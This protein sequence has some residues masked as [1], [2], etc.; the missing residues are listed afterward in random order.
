MFSPYPSN[1]RN[2]LMSSDPQGQAG[3]LKRIIQKNLQVIDVLL[4]GKDDEDRALRE[5]LESR[6][7]NRQ[8]LIQNVE[9][10]NSNI[11][12]YTIP[13]NLEIAKQKRL[14]KPLYKGDGSELLNCFSDHQE[15]AKF[16]FAYEIYLEMF[17]LFYGL[18][19]IIGFQAFVGETA[20]YF[21]CKDTGINF[22]LSHC[23]NCV[24]G[25]SGQ[26]YV[27]LV[28]L[29]MQIFGIII[30]KILFNKWKRYLLNK[31]KPELKYYTYS[32]S[33]FCL[34]VRDLPKETSLQSIKEFFEKTLALE[35]PIKIR[36]AIL[37]REG[38]KIN[39]NIKRR[40]EYQRRKIQ[41]ISQQEGLALCSEKIMEEFSEELSSKKKRRSTT[42]F[43]VEIQNNLK[44]PDHEEHLPDFIGCAIVCFET[45][46]M[47]NKVKEFYKS[48]QRRYFCLPRKKSFPHFNKANIK[49]HNLPDPAD[50]IWVNINASKTVQ[51]IKKAI[52]F[53]I[54][55]VMLIIFSALSISLV[56]WIIL[57]SGNF[58]L[59]ATLFS[60]QFL[61]GAIVRIIGK[62]ASQFIAYKSQNELEKF[63]FGYLLACDIFVFN[64]STWGYAF[65]YEESKTKYYQVPL[66][67]FATMIL[68]NGLFY[69]QAYLKDFI[70]KHSKRKQI[71]ADGTNYLTQREAEEYY[72]RMKLNFLRRTIS[73]FL[74]LTVAMTLYMVYP[75]A[76][77]VCFLVQIVFILID[78]QLIARYYTLSFESDA[79]LALECYRIFNH[80]T[81]LQ[82]SAHTIFETVIDLSYWQDKF[83]DKIVP[84]IFV[85]S[86]I[87]LIIFG[88]E[89]LIYGVVC[90]PFILF[91][92][93]KKKVVIE[94][95][96]HLQN[97]YEKAA[98]FFET[99]YLMSYA[100]SNNKKFF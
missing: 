5:K 39:Q 26:S 63:R 14:T 47:R 64:F 82:I 20:S 40:K 68:T 95:H 83:S 87:A 76:I 1:L 69:A 85:P 57:S 72:T 75:I 67:I 98:Q 30:V 17:W 58:Y 73:L 34:L 13:A 41:Q 55:F 84:G 81:L 11:P 65:Y 23:F 28:K 9:A 66:K 59:E 50:V 27:K 49:I 70:S 52:L 4:T 33:K 100:Y 79:E 80:L 45:I 29:I 74:P 38:D 21:L 99:T 93:L 42:D 77:P 36:G 53:L 61:F 10:S 7:Q 2:R 62:I 22:I 97:D 25:D 43:H 24:K 91:K 48:T 15:F 56:D 88:I 19:I 3:I 86:Q 54:L 92:T 60:L 12:W 8:M 94:N 89:M 78:K 16:S 90:L 51:Q 6:F 96:G 46:E 35:T 32:E 37:V 71:R 44:E 18:W 31:W